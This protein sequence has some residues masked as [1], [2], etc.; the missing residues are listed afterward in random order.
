MTPPR[1][2]FFP[3]PPAD[4]VKLQLDAELVANSSTR[5]NITN[6]TLSGTDD[7]ANNYILYTFEPL[8][9]ATTY[10]EWIFR[11]NTSGDYASGGDWKSDNEANM[12]LAESTW[13]HDGSSFNAAS[14]S[15]IGRTNNLVRARWNGSSTDVTNFWNTLQAGETTEVILNWS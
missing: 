6:A 8:R 9:K 2:L 7:V 12:I 1:W 4:G 14:L 3:T 5:F 13:T 11:V 10:I 15:F